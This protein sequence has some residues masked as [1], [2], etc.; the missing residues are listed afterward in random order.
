MRDSV[1]LGT[2]KETKVYGYKVNFCAGVYMIDEKDGNLSI[3][4]LLDRANIAQKAVKN[5]YNDIRFEIY[6]NI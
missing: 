4:N 2:Y 3:N 1:T 5:L 6:S